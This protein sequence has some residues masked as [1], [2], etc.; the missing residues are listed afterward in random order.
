MAQ[1]SAFSTVV[2]D[3][4]IYS[5]LVSTA[6]S[7]DDYQIPSL[8]TQERS[9][10]LVHHVDTVEASAVLVHRIMPDS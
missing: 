4:T 3:V 5:I 7:V 6:L 2:S 10:S 9:I 1:F 8:S